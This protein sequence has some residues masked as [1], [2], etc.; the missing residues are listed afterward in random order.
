[1]AVL[2]AGRVLLIAN[3]ASRRGRLAL[4]GVEAALRASGIRHELALTTCTGHAR[5]IALARGRDFE[6]VLALGGDGTAGDVIAGLAHSGI[7]VGVLPGGTGNLLARALRI[8]LDPV[9][10]ARALVRAPPAV[11]DVGRFDDGRCLTFAAGVGIDAMMVAGAPAELKRRLGVL[12]YFVSGTRAALSRP[13]FRLR[14]VI[15]GTALETDAWTVFIANFG[16]VLGG[17]MHLGPG[18]SPHDGRLDLCVFSPVT[19]ADA[20]AV[21]WRLFR[22]DFRPHR[23]MRFVQGSEIALSTEPPRPLQ[24]DGELIGSTPVRIRVEPGAATL[25]VPQDR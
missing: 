18:I 21:A 10:A 1:V 9:A 4:P 16:E 6:R 5:D 12:T 8:P 19:V 15:D 11:F 20:V 2:T 22:N 3:P 23:C 25:L 17:L 13:N 14:A 24:S 7:P